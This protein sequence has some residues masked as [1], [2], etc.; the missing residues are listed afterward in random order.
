MGENRLKRSDNELDLEDFFENGTVGLHL[1]GANG[2]ILKANRADYEPLGYRA[3]EYI[4]Q[5][6]SRFHADEETISDILGKLT[7]GE[8][9]DKYPARLL[10]KNGTVRHV[11]ISSNVCFRNGEFVNTRCF[12]VD[13]T[14][15]VQAEHALREA[16]E[17]L[18][19]TY[20]NVL[21]GIAE[22]DASGCFLRVNE[23][24][25]TIT[26]Y[27]K[28][29]LLAKT[30]FDITHPDDV[31]ADHL[32]FARQVN[33]EISGY[34]ITKRYV[35][36]DGRVIWIEVAS[37]TVRSETGDFV[38]GVRMV[39]DITE[40]HAAEE[41][42]KLLLAEL[43]HRVK[44]TLATVQALAAHTARHATS[45]EDFRRRFEPRLIALSTAHD[46]LTRNNWR[47]ASLK[48]VVAGELKAHDA[49][50][51][52]SV[53]GPD[54]ILSPR[55]SLSLSMALHELTTNA[56][57]Y[58][59]LS[60]PA[61]RVDVQWQVQRDDASPYPIGVDITWVESGGPPVQPPSHE[62]FGSRLLRI[63]SAELKGDLV[64]H[65]GG[66]GLEWRLRFPLHSSDFD[67]QPD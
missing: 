19:A 55:M 3:E 27:P 47:G 2:T 33:G 7:A 20:E 49:P 60:V 36:K 12:T 14:E 54:L 30:F 51:H 15:K 8:K 44:N 39:Q 41:H 52:T 35:R 28:D 29:E 32:E 42:K 61:G 31:A 16:Q 56:L 24:F 9:L 21:A 23:A 1:V 45:A 10:A 26:G 34:R 53:E 4:G 65:W 37:S 18:A 46:R 59:A 58:G 25:E 11:L 5:P 48:E 17:R 6:I 40:R 57:K 22:C 64:V 38:F 13:V 50:G 63:T 66:G 43:N 67:V 62:G